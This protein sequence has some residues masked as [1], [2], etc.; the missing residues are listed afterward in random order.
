MPRRAVEK[1]PG[2][3]SRERSRRARA[4]RRERAPTNATAGAPRRPAGR[5][6]GAGDPY[7]EVVWERRDA[8]IEDEHGRV[9]FAQEGV[10]VPATWS[11]LATD[12]V[13][14]RY[15]AG[16][17]GTSARETSVRQLVSRVAGTIAG[18]VEA[19]R[20]GLGARPGEV[21]RDLARLLLG[22]RAAF[23]S[24]VWF[25]VGV[26]RGKPQCSACFIVGLPDRL[27]A[28][29]E[30]AAVEGRIFS[31]GSGAGT[32]FST[33]RGSM[34]ATS[35]GGL[36]SGPVAFLRGLDALA[37]AVKSGGRTRRAAKMAI[38]DADHPDV[39]AFVRS[40]AEEEEKARVLAGGGF[41]TGER[42]EPEASLGFQNEN[43]SVRV[44]DAFLRA[45]ESDGEWALTARTTG[46]VVERL[47]ARELFREIAR[48]AHACGDPGLQFADTIAS[49]NP[50]PATGPIRA[51]NPCAEFVFLDDTACNLCS[52]DVAKF[53][54]R[55]APVDPA[56]LASAVRLLVPAMDAI[57]DAAG[58]P[59]AAITRNSRRL[60]PLGLGVTNLGT[61]LLS[62]ALPYDSDEGRA[63][64]AATLALVGGEATATSARLAEALGPFA[65]WRRNREAA[66]G[67]LARHRAAAEALPRSPL[68]DA[69][70]EAWRR[71]E[72]AAAR[73]GLRN[74]Q[75]TC[76][77][78]AGTVSFL[79]DCDTTGL[80]PELSLRKEKKLSGGGRL[81]L[82][83]RSVPEALAR[84]GYGTREAAAIAAY[85]EATGSVEGAP[86]LDPRHL[87]VF[88][89]A[90][91]A[92]PGGRA[93][94]PEAHLA[95]LE[96]V[97]PFLSGAAS[98]TVNLPATSTVDDVLRVYLSAWRRGLKAVAVYR[99]RS[100]VVQPLSPSAEAPSPG[101]FPDVSPPAEPDALVA[102]CRLCEAPL[103]P[104]GACL[105][106]PNCGASS[107][108][109]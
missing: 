15:F 35:S 73:H 41:A 29:L 108:C 90:L 80:E 92:R 27:D 109:A 10:E 107:G 83:N 46:R 47:R 71:A 63:L 58:Y 89:T 84:L 77:A 100:K 14:S 82:V 87:P 38:L 7:A 42:F 93:L 60:R 74:A 36:A 25:N 75:V 67:V 70:R 78:P 19:A 52:L 86:G 72:R 40:K 76:I 33:L 57:V 45:V 91:P 17:P 18:W 31:K 8:R 30:H 88:D 66:L 49:W 2:T 97:Q 50:V 13:A 56:S 62:R 12:L 37:G 98:K 61:L 9:V 68:A 16:A 102:R 81:R 48:A 99:D 59:T 32:N 21:H 11:Q 105:R 106:C 103:I 23:N 94:S 65:E 44:P 24:P 4:P 96:A 95:M 6:S 55:D 28:I 53:P 5:A 26:G 3:T 69:A 64:A 1:D 43:H 85:A 39:L 101:L 20:A 54:G 22:Q 79:M 104:G 34:E 51:T